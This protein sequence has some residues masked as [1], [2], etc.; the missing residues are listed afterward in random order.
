MSTTGYPDFYCI[1]SQ[2]AATT[3]LYHCLKAHPRIHATA[4]KEA[5]Y[6]DS[7]YVPFHRR[8]H[9]A[10][11]RQSKEYFA[12]RDR[13]GFL[14]ALRV[15]LSPTRRNAERRMRWWLSQEGKIIDD[16]WYRGLFAEARPDQIRF[17]VTPAYAVLP[18][19]GIAH[20]HRLNPEAR[21][22]LI[23]R[24]PVERSFSH[25]KMLLKRSQ[26][27]LTD[28][29]LFQSATSPLVS[30]RDQYGAILDRWQARFPPEQFLVAFYEEVLTA[31]LALLRR[32]CEFNG[33]EYRSRYFSKARKVLFRGPRAS[34]SNGLRAKLLAYHGET[35]REMQRRFPT[36]TQGWGRA[37]QSSAPRPHAHRM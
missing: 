31:P 12:L 7:L 33:I 36:A 16:E 32:I 22:L 23:L 6:F 5:H 26:R 11:V 13:S 21:V 25:A 14:P 2:K 9:Q 30:S 28:E 3:W 35:I 4:F 18:P 17:D 20:V 27:P 37:P 24:D 8:I 10:R 19:K 29:L 34:L 1:G 15:L